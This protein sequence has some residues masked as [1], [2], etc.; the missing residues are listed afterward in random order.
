MCVYWLTV[1][2]SRGARFDVLPL[3]AIWYMLFLIAEA[4]YRAFC[5][6]NASAYIDNPQ[7][8]FISTR[9][10]GAAGQIKR[11]V[12]DP[13]VHPNEGMGNTPELVRVETV[14][15]ISADRILLYC[16]VALFQRNLKFTDKVRSAVGI[17]CF[18][19]IC[20]D[21]WTRT[22]QLICKYSFR[23]DWVA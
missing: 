14:S 4:I 1:D 9:S 11:L 2:I 5:I 23:F 8:G 17:P 20:S 15:W 13:L 22:E 21:W 6:S 7:R 3:H 16:F 12:F 19:G 18:V 10:L